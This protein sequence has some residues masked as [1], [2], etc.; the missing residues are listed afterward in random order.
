MEVHVF[1]IFHIET[2]FWTFS[3][4]NIYVLIETFLPYMKIND[5][6]I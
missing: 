3:I 2:E 5:K 4:Q 1:H 6:F